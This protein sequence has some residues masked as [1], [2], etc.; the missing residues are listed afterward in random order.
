ML[1]YTAEFARNSI[2]L[3]QSNS[4]ERHRTTNQIQRTY[5]VITKWET[6]VE[7]RS[8]VT[9]MENNT[10]THT[11]HTTDT[12]IKISRCEGW[13]L[14]IDRLAIIHVRKPT[15]WASLRGWRA[16]A[17]IVPTSTI[18]WQRSSGHRSAKMLMR[19]LNSVDGHWS[20][21]WQATRTY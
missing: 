2:T 15:E 20:A 18:P 12:K 17:S 6:G 3:S 7:C 14:S 5:V 1:S 9:S 19:H 4:I 13:P 16:L 8:S 10:R 11:T 21:V